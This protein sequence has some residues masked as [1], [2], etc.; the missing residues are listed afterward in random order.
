MDL[1]RPSNQV[2]TVAETVFEEKKISLADHEKDTWNTVEPTIKL[3]RWWA[4]QNVKVM[5]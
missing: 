3:I 4:G 1:C 2:D 5:F